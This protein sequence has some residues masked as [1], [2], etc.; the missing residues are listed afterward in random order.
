MTINSSTV[1][2]SA[3]ALVTRMLYRKG[4]L[5]RHG[6][7]LL[8]VR[9]A[10]D[11]HHRA[12]GDRSPDPTEVART[13]QSL[14]EV[15][16]DF[17]EWVDKMPSPFWP[18]AKNPSEEVAA[19]LQAEYVDWLQK[20]LRSQSRFRVTCEVHPD[21]YSDDIVLNFKPGSG[22]GR[23]R[24]TSL[25]DGLRSLVQDAG[26][27][28]N[29]YLLSGITERDFEID[30][31]RI[32]PCI[33]LSVDGGSM[34]SKVPAAA[35]NVDPSKQHLKLMLDLEF[36]LM[37]TK[38]FND[39]SDPNDHALVLLAKPLKGVLRLVLSLIHI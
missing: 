6:S 10:K 1:K 12:V 14:K 3:E 26:M 24:A 23:D 34:L 28:E 25:R 38:W 19:N 21:P 22:N 16:T 13:T 31:A 29:L 2:P 36:E 11:A 15:R 33:S 4:W 17:D 8:R 20:M 37:D 5:S 7:E 32:Q 39:A 18:T 27:T 30:N 35:F 9:R